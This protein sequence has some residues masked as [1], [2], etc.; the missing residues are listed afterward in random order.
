MLAT[1]RLLKLVLN[2]THETN[3]WDGGPHCQCHFC[4]NT[5]MFSPN[6]A[7]QSVPFISVIYCRPLL[8]VSCFFPS[9]HT[10]L[11]FC[12]RTVSYINCTGL[13]HKAIIVCIYFC[14][15]LG[16]FLFHIYLLAISFLDYCFLW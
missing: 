12:V 3:T 9:Y 11:S 7:S 13:F 14:H 16:N 8:T 4:N 15:S 10:K 1:I 2:M 5:I 6:T